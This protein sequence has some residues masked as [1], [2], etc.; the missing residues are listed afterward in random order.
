[1]RPCDVAAVRLGN[2]LARVSARV[3][4]LCCLFLLPVAI[5]D[6]RTS[7][8]WEF[9][10]IRRL[11]ARRDS[12]FTITEFCGWQKLPFRKS[13]GFVSANIDI[14]AIGNIRCLGAA[15]GC[16]AF[17]NKP[18]QPLCG[19]APGGKFWTK[20]AEPYPNKLCKAFAL[21]FDS[22]LAARRAL[23]L[24]ATVDT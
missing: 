24:Q 5:E 11:L 16:C 9:P 21:A 7:W 20:I 23:L 14:S 6:P 13:T 8:L 17:T 10:P 2:L 4:I 12:T 22:G 1:M 15:R 3:L 19:L 18:H